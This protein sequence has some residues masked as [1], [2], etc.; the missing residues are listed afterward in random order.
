MFSGKVIVS[1]L[2]TRTHGVWQRNMTFTCVWSLYKVYTEEYKHKA[3][4]HYLDIRFRYRYT[5]D[6]NDI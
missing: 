4:L 3:E 5:L 2:D 6:D 1:A